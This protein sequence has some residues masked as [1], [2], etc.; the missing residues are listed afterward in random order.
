MT[1]LMKGSEV[2]VVMKEKIIMEIEELRASG[3]VA[4]FAIVRVDARLDDLAY[5]RN[6]IK[7]LEGMEINV[8][9][10]GNLCRD[11]D[12]E[13]VSSVTGYITPVSGGVGTVT[14]SLLVKYDIRA[15]KA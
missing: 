14:S 5:E 6:A 1:V 13:S 10:A 7:K 4:T 2:A 9:Q 8:D 15:A 11:V 12:F 3:I